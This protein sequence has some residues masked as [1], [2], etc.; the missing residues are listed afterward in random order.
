MAYKRRETK[1]S[2]YSSTLFNT[3]DALFP[4]VCIPQTIV[5]TH[6]GK[7]GRQHYDKKPRLR[8][9]QPVAK[10]QKRDQHK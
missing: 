2:K 3:L 10:I 9:F 5:S 1:T 8:G 6:K 7:V 4:C